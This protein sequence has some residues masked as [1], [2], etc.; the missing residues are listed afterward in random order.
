MSVKE[1]F[2]K[3]CKERN[4]KEKVTAMNAL[5]AHHKNKI[6][7]G[8]SIAST[9]VEYAK[10][11]NTPI[12]VKGGFDIVRVAIQNFSHASE[13]FFSETNGWIPIKQNGTNLAPIF[14]DVLMNY[15]AKTIAANDTRLTYKIYETPA[16]N[17]GYRKSSYYSREETIYCQ[18]STS[19]EGIIDFLIQEKLKSLDTNFISCNAASRWNGEEFEIFCENIL[20]IPS[21]RCS[22]FCDY[23]SHCLK[24]SVNRS[25]IFYGPPGTGK[26]TLS[27][28]IVKQLGFKTL[29]FRYQMGINYE[30]LK[31]VIDV[32]KIDAVIIDDFD[33]VTDSEQMLEF[34]ETLKRKVKLVIGLANSLKKFHP[35]I[36]RPGRF[37][38]I[39]KVNYLEEETIEELMGSV[40]KDYGKKVKFWPIA[41]INE[42]MIR[43]RLKEGTDLTPDFE[44]L[45]ERVK[46]QIEL[47]SDGTEKLET[48]EKPEEKPK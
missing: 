7:M 35:A 19:K 41:Y 12:L 26:T 15:P 18:K 48:D 4:V 10:N 40:Y 33:L 24:N 44:E 43:A 27:Q 21:K 9:F 11:K 8:W 32:F 46:R 25:L 14:A 6:D 36:L 30:T 45:H 22:Q 29:K 31:F 20:Y 1:K 38:E 37:D 28:S 13:Q 17:I 42:L 2:E 47:C 39:I 5:L 16:G 3:F 23:I 34:L